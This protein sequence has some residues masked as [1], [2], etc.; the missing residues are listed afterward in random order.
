LTDAAFDVEAFTQSQRVFIDSSSGHGCFDAR[1]GVRW[2][3]P[4]APDSRRVTP[5]P[6]FVS[7][8]RVARAGVAIGASLAVGLA[9]AASG[10]VD[11][12]VATLVVMGFSPDRGVL[13]TAF[14]VEAAGAAAGTLLAGTR[15]LP[16]LAGA[17]LFVAVFHDTFTAETRSAL[18]ASGADGTFD[19]IGWVVSLITL[20]TSIVVLGWATTTLVR[21]VRRGLIQAAADVPA[22]WRQRRARSLFRPLAAVLG[23]AL[24]VIA[25]P[26]LGDMLNFEPDS[27]MRQGSAQGPAVTGAATLPSIAASLS[28]QLIQNGGVVSGQSVPPTAIL[29]S[30]RPWL[31]S[32]P[33]GSGAVT[34][35]VIP[36]PWGPSGTSY[37][38][39]VYLPPGYATGMKSYPVLYATPHAMPN[40]I[41]GANLLTMLDTLT[42]SGDMP[43]T[44]VAFVSEAG[45]P[46]PDSECANSADGREWFDRW[47]VDTLVPRVDSALRTIPN[48]AARAVMGFSQGGFCAASL[49]TRHPDV[50]GTDISFS[51]YFQAGVRTSET[52]NAWLPYEGL[53]SY[54]DQFSP[55]LV[56][57]SIA[58]ALRPNLFFELSANPSEAFFGAQY[59]TFVRVL[60][61]AGIAASLFPSPVGHAWVAVRAQLPQLLT[62][63]AARMAALGVFAT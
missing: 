17:G 53:P 31:N 30:A 3:T 11:A 35:L 12:T 40:W 16:A 62:T 10:S 6:G 61:G 47:V 36:A 46:Y 39:Y 59:A 56:V 13:I 58:P 25:L 22:A 1:N 18:A 37:N 43:P 19:P 29:S 14:V 21:L 41:H 15:R 34:H 60:H 23:T 48:P 20:A 42:D 33:T 63:W 57:P 32:I 5:P 38:A 45:G 24:L 7:R 28:P 26:T 50:F 2:A 51:G 27:H 49:V 8:G 52:P 9:L 4:D 54:E 44:I 55:D